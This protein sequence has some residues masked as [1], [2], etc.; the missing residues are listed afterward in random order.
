MKKDKGLHIRLSQE[1]YDNM[2]EASKQAGLTISEYIRTV[3]STITSVDIE[4][5]RKAIYKM[6][7]EKTKEDIKKGLEPALSKMEIMH[8]KRELYKELVEDTNSAFNVIRRY[9]EEA[10]GSLG[11]DGLEQLNLFNDDRDGGG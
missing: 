11:A 9:M 2:K 8:K 3:G 7:E 1:E 5:I 10:A 4:T 6:V